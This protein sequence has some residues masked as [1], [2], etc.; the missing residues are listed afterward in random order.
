VFR[1]AGTGHASGQRAARAQVGTIWP[2]AAA[3]ELSLLDSK[4]E[5]PHQLVSSCGG[6]GFIIQTALGR[7]AQHDPGVIRR[8]LIRT[9]ASPL[10][11]PR[12]ALQIHF[13]YTF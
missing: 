8:D 3:N 7:D 13:S 9:V 12:P 6:S 2:N 10:L 4:P 11:S 1:H 5:P